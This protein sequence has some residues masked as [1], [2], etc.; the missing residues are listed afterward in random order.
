MNS[1]EQFTLIIGILAILFEA[2]KHLKDKIKLWF[3]PN[4]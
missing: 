1:F 2:F 3:N 4:H